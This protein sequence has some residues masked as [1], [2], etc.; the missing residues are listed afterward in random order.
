LTQHVD[1]L[2]ALLVHRCR[3]EIVDR[4][5]GLRLHW[6]GKR[7]GIFLE[8]PQPQILHIGDSPHPMRAHVARKAGFAKNGEASPSATAGTSRGR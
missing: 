5:V 3:I 6:M 1:D 7:S 2:G 8:L 4:D